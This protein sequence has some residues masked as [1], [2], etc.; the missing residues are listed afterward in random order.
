MRRRRFIIASVIALAAMAARRLRL[1]RQPCCRMAPPADAPFWTP[2]Q[3]D[4]LRQALAED[5]DWSEEVD[6]LAVLLQAV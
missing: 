5:A 4:F 1:Y 6:E 3:A 2:A